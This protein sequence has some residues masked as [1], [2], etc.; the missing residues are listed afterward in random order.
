MISSFKNSKVLLTG[1]HGFLGKHVV[2]KFKQY[3]Y[4]NLITPS[5]KEFDLRIQSEAIELFDK[6]KP[7]IV[8][9]MAA[10]MGGIGSNRNY[11][12][13]F[14]YDNAMINLNLVHTSYINNVKKFVGIGTVCSY[15]KFCPI[16]FKEEDLWNG[17]PEETNAPYGLAKKMMLVQTQAYANQ[18][19]FQGI[20]L[21][22]VNLYGPGDNFDLNSSHVI[23]A[24]IRKCILAKELGKKYINVWGTGTASREFIYVKDAAEAILEATELYNEIDP[25][26]IGSS[27]QIKI[28]ELVELIKNLTG[29]DGV[30]NW[31]KS[32]PDGQPI[33]MLDTTKAY[34][35]FGFRAK[36][37]L[38]DGLK[39]T[40]KYYEKMYLE[41]DLKDEK[42]E[43]FLV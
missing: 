6:T 27:E 20:H 30:I 7:E 39:S 38:N 34:E 43:E 13:E 5:S 12:G 1:A 33:R 21:L 40:I 8:I 32:K 29:F 35:K 2:E 15:P 36:T 18:Y 16:P 19:K 25:I 31:D 42:I 23:P 28:K 10:K 17:Y 9:H 41:N 14:F 4:S 22:M 3:G 11:P 37:K 26:N 24:L